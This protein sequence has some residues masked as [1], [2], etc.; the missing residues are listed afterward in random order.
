MKTANLLLTAACA[1]SLAACG[2]QPE[3]N[4]ATIQNVAEAPAED[5][6]LTGET[7][8][9]SPPANAISPAEEPATNNMA[10]GEP[11]RRAPPAQKA[12]P[13]PRPADPADP[14]AGHDMSNMSGNHQ[15]S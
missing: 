4:Q 14:H 15:S 1:A 7:N 5:T 13:A 8:L 12:E 11:A 6:N 10:R 3:P 2:A 9:A